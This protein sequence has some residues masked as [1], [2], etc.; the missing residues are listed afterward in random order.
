M[1]KQYSSE[2]KARVPLEAVRGENTFL[3][4]LRSMK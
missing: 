3:N 4:Y 1:R 2:Y